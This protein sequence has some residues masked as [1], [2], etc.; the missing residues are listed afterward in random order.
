MRFWG[1]KTE[2]DRPTDSS[3]SQIAPE[4]R[5]A[6]AEG[7]G[8][9]GERGVPPQSAFRSVQSRVSSVLTVTLMVILSAGLLIWYYANAMGRGAK[10]RNSALAAQQRKAQGE[11]ALPPFTTFHLPRGSSNGARAQRD[12]LHASRNLTGESAIAAASASHPQQDSRRRW[13][14]FLGTRQRFRKFRSTRSESALGHRATYT[15]PIRTEARH[16]RKLPHQ[17][18]LDRRL[19]GPVLS[20]HG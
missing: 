10:V 9:S 20:A 8:V 16:P 11:S 19:S 15:G 4:T 17:L 1:R 7:Q 6:N 2:A 18:L 12:N 13:S 3:E 14:K 5:D